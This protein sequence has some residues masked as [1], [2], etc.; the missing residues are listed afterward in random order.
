MKW[1]VLI[2]LAI[3]VNST[4]ELRYSRLEFPAHDYFDCVDITEEI[5]EIGTAY[6]SDIPYVRNFFLVYSNLVHKIK[7]EC[8]YANP[9]APLPKWADDF[10]GPKWYMKD[11]AYEPSENDIDEDKASKDDK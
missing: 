4:D 7:A 1:V 10:V 5:N 9:E 6:N 8:V 11:E 3:F 2:Y